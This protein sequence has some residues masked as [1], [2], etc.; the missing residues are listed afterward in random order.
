MSDAVCDGP[1]VARTYAHR[2]TDKETNLEPNSIDVAFIC[3]VYHHMEYREYNCL[4]DVVES[5]LFHSH[6]AM[7]EFTAAHAVAQRERSCDRWLR[8]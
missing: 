7:A 3:D 6:R 8:H 1:T 2:C 4:S 5:C